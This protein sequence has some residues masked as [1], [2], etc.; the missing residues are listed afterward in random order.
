MPP[1][2]RRTTAAAAADEHA[3]ETADAAA[4]AAAAKRA[5]TPAAA[6]ADEQAAGAF[7][8]PTNDLIFAQ[9]RTALLG[10]QWQER[11]G[12]LDKSPASAPDV[13]AAL[14]VKFADLMAEP[15]AGTAATAAREA[16]EAAAKKIEDLR[17][18]L[19]AKQA[20]TDAAREAVERQAAEAAGAS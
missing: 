17:D 12:Y 4:G 10:L 16:A 8:E 3:A 15:V 2:T 11:A 5:R 13:P 9:F 20:E 19:A 6:A 18:E 7:A 1:S 14:H